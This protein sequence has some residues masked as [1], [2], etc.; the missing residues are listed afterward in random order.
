MHRYFFCLFSALKGRNITNLFQIKQKRF[1][2]LLASLR[3]LKVCFIN[4]VEGFAVL[5]QRLL[6]VLLTPLYRRKILRLN[7]PYFLIYK[8]HCYKTW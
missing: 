3:E 7:R 1:E 5:A 6:L 8:P 4:F 2:R